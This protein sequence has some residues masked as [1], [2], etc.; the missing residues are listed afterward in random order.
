MGC[1]LRVMV[2]L[3]TKYWEQDFRNLG[4][5]YLKRTI[6]YGLGE[7]A[8][9][10]LKEWVEKGYRD[11]IE[12]QDYGIISEERQ[13][14]LSKL[15]LNELLDILF[16]QNKA[17]STLQIF[18][19]NRTQAMSGLE[20]VVVKVLE[21]VPT[22]SEIV[23]G[24]SK[25]LRGV[26]QGEKGLYVPSQHRFKKHGKEYT[27]DVEIDLEGTEVGKFFFVADHPGSGSPAVY[28]DHRM[29]YNNAPTG[30][31]TY[32]IG[33]MKRITVGKELKPYPSYEGEIRRFIWS[34]ICAN[35]RIAP[36]NLP[37]HTQ[38]YEGFCVVPVKYF[39]VGDNVLQDITKEQRK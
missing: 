2:L 39:T 26:Y 25:E 10:T 38:N 27:V 19:E 12:D 17:A 20:V 29:I 16:F 33:G 14:E 28:F 36:I 18:P 1:H 13:A 15:N 6:S 37:E 23:A 8:R 30:A 21:N 35:T 34:P 5:T 7:S 9:D 32:L 11:R 31:N 22:E 4:I 3:R 24:K